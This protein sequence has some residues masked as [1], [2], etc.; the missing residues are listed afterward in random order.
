MPGKKVS[1]KTKYVSIYT[2]FGELV[3][4]ARVNIMNDMFDFKTFHAGVLAKSK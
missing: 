1:I 2:E 4:R 3:R